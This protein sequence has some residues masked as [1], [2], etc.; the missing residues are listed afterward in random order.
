MTLSY[1]SIFFPQ[2]KS[3][4][5]HFQII[6]LRNLCMEIQ[7]DKISKPQRKQISYKAEGVAC[8]LDLRMCKI[9]Q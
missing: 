5:S 7:Y 2:G 9:F 4:N 3:I 8:Q 1:V 6:S